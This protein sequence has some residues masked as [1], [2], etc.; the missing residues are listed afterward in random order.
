[1][2]SMSPWLCRLC[3]HRLCHPGLHRLHLRCLYCPGL[4]RLRCPDLHRLCH[5]GLH[6]LC[7]PDLRRLCHPG[8]RRLH[9]PTPRRL[10]CPMS[11]TSPC[12]AYVAPACVACN[13]PSL[14]HTSAAASSWPRRAHPLR[15]TSATS[16]PRPASHI[17]SFIA[18][19]PLRCTLPPASRLASL[20]YHSPIITFINSSCISGDLQLQ[21][22]L[23]AGADR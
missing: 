10:H 6:C 4:R 7:C 3:L 21:S 1:M 8:L 19:H 14:H 15:R 22:P 17:A 11:L 16:S 5:P 18:P 13:A 23:G 2:L 9:R 20:C 12:V